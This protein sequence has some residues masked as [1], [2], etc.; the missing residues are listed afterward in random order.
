MARQISHSHELRLKK[1]SY[2]V[3]FTRQAEVSSELSNIE[4]LKRVKPSRDE[5][6]RSIDTLFG[7]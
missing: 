5:P 3:D 1:E 2:R 6:Q 4:S 7:L